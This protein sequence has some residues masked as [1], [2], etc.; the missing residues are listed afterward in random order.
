VIVGSINVDL[1]FTV[2]RLPRAGETV[3]A[4]RFERH[5]GGK[6]ANQAVAA[7]RAGA[8][9]KFVGAVGNDGAGTQA[10][11][12]LEREGVDVSKVIRLGSVATGLAAIVVDAEGE[13]QIAVASGANANLD[14]RIVE[15]ALAS[16]QPAPDGVCLL[17]FEIS[18]AAL[19]A[20]ARGVSAA[21][22]TTIVVNPAPARALPRELTELHPL[23]TPNA[24][25]A[26]AL[27]NEPDPESAAQKLSATLDGPVIVTLG[28][29][30][31]L[32]VAGGDCE[33]F[34]APTVR[35]IDTT[36]AGDVFNGVLAASLAQGLALGHAVQRAV[37]AASSSVQHHGA[38][39]TGGHYP[40]THVRTTP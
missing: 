36:G 10:L 39:A 7:A 19:L 26:A 37:E 38:R 18:D 31:A 14:E 20:A 16:M 6:G 22:I 17:N 15:R 40:C 12:E 11:G 5:G 9:V 24:T 29:G 30:G 35:A 33:R 2:E 32:V 8:T 21:G 27:A 1:V 25:E 23:L 28:A 34:T 3:A 13:N 4:G